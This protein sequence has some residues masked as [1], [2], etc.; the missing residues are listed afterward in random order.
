MS[1]SSPGSQDRG[2]CAPAPAG[3]EGGCAPRPAPGAAPPP[4]PALAHATGSGETTSSAFVST[5]GQSARAWVACTAAHGSHARQRMGHMHA[6]PARQPA[7]PGS[8]QA[9]LRACTRTDRGADA[10]ARAQARLHAGVLCCLSNGPP[11]PVRSPGASPCARAAHAPTHLVYGVGRLVLSARPRARDAGRSGGA[12]ARRHQLRGALQR[13][14]VPAPARARVCLPAPAGAQ[15]SRQACPAPA[16]TKQVFPH[17]AAGRCLP[18]PANGAPTSWRARAQ[19][20]R[21]SRWALTGPPGRTRRR[22]SGRPAAAG[23]TARGGAGG[24]R[25]TPRARVA[26]G[27]SSCR[28]QAPPHLCS[29]RSGLCLWGARGKLQLSPPP[30]RG[31]PARQGAPRVRAEQQLAL[32]ACRVLLGVLLHAVCAAVPGVLAPASRA[33]P[34]SNAQGNEVLHTAS[35]STLDACLE[36]HI[37]DASALADSLAR[38]VRHWRCRASVAGAQASGASCDAARRPLTAV[39]SACGRSNRQAAYL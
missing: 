24:R 39:P 16:A 1:R 29:C 15:G 17:H 23:R 27:P 5:C 2:H 19:S 18:G 4:A 11:P 6:W 37:G 33:A 31:G 20:G 3:A 32:A 10:C 8:A 14:R 7:G 38:Q 35:G 26:P 34:A 13:V 36:H 12:A 21:S 28:S 30:P 9:R 22:C 25:G